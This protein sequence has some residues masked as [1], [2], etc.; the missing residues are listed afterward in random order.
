MLFCNL[1]VFL[2]YYN[3]VIGIAN[4][5][6]VCFELNIKLSHLEYL[7]FC[8]LLKIIGLEKHTNVSIKIEHKPI[9]EYSQLPRN[10]HHGEIQQPCAK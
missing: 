7:T 10:F 4:Y 1:L 8:E 5:M 9:P 6:G 3:T 2:I